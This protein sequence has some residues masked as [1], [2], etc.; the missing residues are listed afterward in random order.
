MEFQKASLQTPQL[1][2]RTY[3][4]LDNGSYY[5]EAID[6]LEGSEV[7]VLVAGKIAE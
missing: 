1:K 6:G 7:L 5:S 2:D 3:P 4:T